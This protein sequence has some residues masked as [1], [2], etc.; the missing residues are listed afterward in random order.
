MKETFYKVKGCIAF[1]DSDLLEWGY[2]YFHSKDKAIERVEEVFNDIIKWCNLQD[3][4]LNIK[5]KNVH[6]KKDGSFISFSIKAWKDDDM[7]QECNGIVIVELA[8]M[9]D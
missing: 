9:E 1:P 6:R 5:P 4:T 2:F 3:P 7:L 8:T